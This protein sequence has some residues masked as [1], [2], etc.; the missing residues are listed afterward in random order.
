MK[1]S[2]TLSVLLVL[3]LISFIVLAI[4]LPLILG[5]SSVIDAIS[6]L[7]YILSFGIAL[8]AFSQAKLTYNNYVSNKKVSIKYIKIDFEEPDFD[9]MAEVARGR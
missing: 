8:I 2:I 6:T 5:S 3:L 9:W 4:I 7:L 1:T